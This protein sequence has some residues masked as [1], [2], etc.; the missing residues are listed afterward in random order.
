VEEE[1]R[2]GVDPVGMMVLM[3]V[4]LVAVDLVVE[5]PS[6]AMDRVYMKE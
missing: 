5:V 4:L 1:E 6:Y 3:L 2:Y